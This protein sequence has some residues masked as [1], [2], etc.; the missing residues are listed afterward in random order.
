[1][2]KVNKKAFTLVELLVT[3][4][5]LGMIAVAI[6]STFASGLNVYKR[7][8]SYAGAET[9]VLLALEKMERDLRNI[10]NFSGI[11]FIDDS[12]RIAFAGLVKTFDR[13]GNQKISLGRISYYLDEGAGTLVKEEQ[14]YPQAISGTEPEQGNSVILAFIEDINFSYYYFDSKAER[15]DIKSSWD[16]GNGI[17]TKVKIEITF[18]DDGKTIKMDRTVFIPVAG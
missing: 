7:V 9:D 1:M 16:A 2:R 8:R 10:F 12:K 3:A 15:Q 18:T 14:D 17:P 11:D 4:S 13:A 5:I 6:F